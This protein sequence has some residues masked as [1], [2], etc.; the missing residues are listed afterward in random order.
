MEILGKQRVTLEAAMHIISD[1][2]KDVL[3]IQIIAGD[4]NQ[5]WIEFYDKTFGGHGQKE[6]ADVVKLEILKIWSVVFDHSK[7]YYCSGKEKARL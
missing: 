7:P 1:K 3:D 4:P 5:A 6:M 2:S